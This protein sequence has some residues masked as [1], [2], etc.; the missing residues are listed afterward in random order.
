MERA[1]QEGEVVTA[2]TRARLLSSIPAAALGNRVFVVDLHVDAITYYFERDMRT[3]HVYARSLVAGVAR[4]IGGDDFVIACTDAGRAKWVEQL[5]H[6]LG[7]TAAFVYKARKS[8]SETEV[9]GVSAHVAGRNVI[10][11]DDMIRTGSSLLGAAQAYLDAGASKVS[12]IST[13]GVLPGDSLSRIES[14]GLLDRL[15]CTDTHPRA[16]ALCS[17]TMEIA[18]VVPL[19]A[20]SLLG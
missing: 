16:H 1:E 19:L 4:R 13:H 11:Y 2:K 7:V 14:S 8:G 5:A 15:V 20:A 10:I 12:A 18:S 3:T 9:S 17:G 6:E